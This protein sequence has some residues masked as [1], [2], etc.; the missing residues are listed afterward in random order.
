MTVAVDNPSPRGN[1]NVRQCNPP[2]FPPFL[3]SRSTTYTTYTRYN[4]YNI[5]R[6]NNVDRETP[7]SPE[8]VGGVVDE[9][10]ILQV[11]TEHGEVFQKVPVDAEARVPVQAVLDPL[12]LRVEDVQQ[13]LRVHLLRGGEDGN[14]RSVLE[15]V[16]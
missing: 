15:K 11:A 7:D 10:D 13:F 9:D 3:S 4:R 6:P 12:P 1:A 8:R 16:F 5:I 14:L 2:P